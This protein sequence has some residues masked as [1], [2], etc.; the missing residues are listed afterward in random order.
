PRRPRH[1]REQRAAARRRDGDADARQASLHARRD[2]GAARLQ[3]RTPDRGV[4]AET[5]EDLHGADKLFDVLEKRYMTDERERFDEARRLVT[6]ALES[7]EGLG[8][9]ENPAQVV[10]DFVLAFDPDAVK[11]DE[12]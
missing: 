7:L 11:D 4:I 8:H 5:R 9:L 2:R 10:S 1:G 6:A 12:P 3:A